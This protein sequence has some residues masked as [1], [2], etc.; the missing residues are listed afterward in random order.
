MQR[1]AATIRI[2]AVLA[3]VL[4][5][6]GA[7]TAADPLP[8]WNDGAAK[9]AILSFVRGA[10]DRNSPQYVD[11]QKRFATFDEDG[12]LWVEHPIYTEVV[13]TLDRVAALAPQ[14]PAWKSTA[15]F[16]A[17]LARNEAA[18][19]K[20]TTKDFEALVAATHSGVSV[21]AFHSIVK[22]WIASARDARWH[23][24]YTDLAYQPML[25]M[26]RYLRANGFKT[27]IVTGGGQEFVRSFAEDVYGIPPSQVIGSAG[28]T[29]F[30]YA[31]DGHAIL[32][33][34]P[35]L[36]LNDNLSGKPED[37]YLFIGQR[38]QAA[39]GNSSGD[40][41]ML[42]YAQGNTG[43]KLM[44]LVLHDDPTREY[45]YGPATGLPNTK[46]GTFPQSLYDEAKANGWIVISM[47]QDWNRIFA[48]GL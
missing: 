2:A 28:V 41:Q 19:A 44:M 10:T 15:P 24:R 46:V 16:K 43:A 39:A 11:P 37:I 36:L 14:H 12:T 26:I 21:A 23:R 33:K 6:A 8:S 20:F 42:E 5:V 17:V 29:T 32:M 3:L 18:I 47:K 7:T 25:E 27:Y 45:A 30:S 4:G 9:Q 13:F 22:D 31:S 48:W 38:P 40:R 35:K 1:L 34:S